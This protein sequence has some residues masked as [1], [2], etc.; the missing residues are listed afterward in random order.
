MS[1][2][3]LTPVLITDD[4]LAAYS[5]LPKNYDYS[6]IRPFI[7]IAEQVWIVD[8]IG[9]PLYKELIEQVA[10]NTVT[11]ENATLLLKI[12]QLEAI[13]VVYEA[14]PFIW[15]SF[16]EKG[17]TLGKSDNSESIKSTDLSVIQN[18]LRS[19]LTSYQ[20]LL[21]QF[22]EDNAECFPL[23]VPD[24]NECCSNPLKGEKR[25]YSNN[26]KKINKNF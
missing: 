11:D 13:A 7:S 22:L 3:F 10:T 25:L 12:Y 6:D 21:K 5:P 2:I 1:E 19:Q 16:T 24:V 20:K 23:Y 18:H 8:I 4:Y 17:I 9:K 14:L 15:T 26:R